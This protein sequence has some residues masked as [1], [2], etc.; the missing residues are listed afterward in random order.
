MKN[1][2]LNKWLYLLII[3]VVLLDQ[4]GKF[5]VVSNIYDYESVTIIPHVLSFTNVL[6][7]GIIF[8]MFFQN[9]NAIVV[10]SLILVCLLFAYLIL[11]N[12]GKIKAEYLTSRIAIAFCLVIGGAASN[13][14]DRVFRIAV[15]DYIRLDFFNFPIFNLADIAITLGAILLIWEIVFPRKTK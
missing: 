15:I 2:K 3:A 10:I 9:N 12:M 1:T 13:I 7:S 8:G 14:I 4:L 6:N 11:S 5:F